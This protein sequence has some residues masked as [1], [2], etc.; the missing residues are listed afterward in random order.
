MRI[1]AVQVEG[2]D[3]LAHTDLWFL[4]VTADQSIVAL[5]LFELVDNDVTI[6]K[7]VVNDHVPWANGCHRIAV[8][9]L[10]IIREGDHLLDELELLLEHIDQRN[11]VHV[12]VIELLGIL[13]VQL[14]Q[15]TVF[16]IVKLLRA[17]F[18]LRD[19]I[20]PIALLHLKLELSVEIQVV[21]HVDT[22]WS[23]SLVL[24]PA[25][26]NLTFL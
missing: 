1:E 9:N 13:H 4:D 11:V 12:I 25:N 2:N 23:V 15:R 8:V 24:S 22:S 26:L 20:E 7:I 18:L 6:K 19:V 17:E 3:P 10:G 14:I 5:C 16:G 21:E